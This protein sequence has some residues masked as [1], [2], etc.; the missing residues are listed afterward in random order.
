MDTPPNNAHVYALLGQLRVATQTRLAV[1]RPALTLPVI[2]I[3]TWRNN[4]HDF[5]A[6]GLAH[7]FFFFTFGSQ[8]ALSSHASHAKYLQEEAAAL[9]CSTCVYRT[10]IRPE[11]RNSTGGK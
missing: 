10:I 6:N 2:S 11:F 1:T 7:Y 5:L 4:N 9:Q 8:T 3:H